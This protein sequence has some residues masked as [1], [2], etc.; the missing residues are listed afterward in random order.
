MNLFHKD[1]HKKDFVAKPYHTMINTT[2]APVVAAA[3]GDLEELTRLYVLGV[4]LEAGDYDK[5]TPL[6][7]SSAG[8]HLDCV[9]FLIKNGV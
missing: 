4:S 7:L 1:M 3:S 9:K 8:G 6:H 5:R 2:M